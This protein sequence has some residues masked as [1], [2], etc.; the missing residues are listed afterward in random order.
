METAQHSRAAELQGL[1]NAAQ[2]AKRS[3]SHSA[4]GVPESGLG[5]PAPGGEQ[6]CLLK[7]ESGRR[8]QAQALLTSSP[9]ADVQGKQSMQ[10]NGASRS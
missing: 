2:A 6:A 5:A 9:A 3:I 1:Q 8:M 10:D 4:N 7:P